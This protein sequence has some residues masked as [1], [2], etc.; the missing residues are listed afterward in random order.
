ME[1][2]STEPQ[3][4]KLPKCVGSRVDYLQIAFQCDLSASTLTTLRHR[5]AAARDHGGAAELIVGRLLA[6]L[7][8]RPGGERFGVRNFDLRAT[9]GL[10]EEGGW[11]L[12]FH[13]AAV[14]LATHSLEDA[15]HMCEEIA[16]SLGVV[17]GRRL[18]RLDLAADFSDFPLTLAM[19][20]DFV[21]PRR[22]KLGQYEPQEKDEIA[23]E[24]RVY[25]VNGAVTGFSFCQKGDLS[26]RIYDKTAEL[27][28]GGNET[29]QAI[30]HT[31][32]SIA[33]WTP[34]EQVTRV[35]FQM[36]GSALDELELRDPSAKRLAERIDPVWQYLT[37]KWLRMIDHDDERK[38]RCT[39]KP[40]WTVVQSALF[41]HATT[42]LATRT[43]RRGG[44]TFEQALGSVLSALHGMRLLPRITRPIDTSED[45]AT[46]ELTR[47]ELDSDLRSLMLDLGV[48]WAMHA[49]TEMQKKLGTDQAPVVLRTKWNAHYM[50]FWSRGDVEMPGRWTVQPEPSGDW[51]LRYVE[52][53]GSAAIADILD[54]ERAAL[55]ARPGGPPI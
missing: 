9:I 32:W 3:G 23:P 17:R 2:T 8:P 44:A 46:R 5:A 30:E 50:R 34:D 39:T 13:V 41:R 1:E 29:K 11:S 52:S 48:T 27:R 31:R 6:E 43:R 33:G 26:A 47:A 51:T 37:R 49:S 14:Y 54:D 7:K 21:M 25:M 10:R 16:A 36:R 28:A 38:S 35:E 18:R 15:V 53:S 22:G 42:E 12:D 19:S 40:L 20:G 24:R 55:Q 45:A 4:D